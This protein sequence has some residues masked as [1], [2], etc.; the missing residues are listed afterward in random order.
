MSFLLKHGSQN[1]IRYLCISLFLCTAGTTYAAPLSTI[2]NS[3]FGTPTGQVPPGFE[4]ISEEQTSQLDF[5]YGGKFIGSSFAS[6]TTDSITLE[7]PYGVVDLLPKLLDKEA[8]IQA[9]SRSLDTNTE[10]IC[11]EEQEC[12][13][14]EPDIAE[15]ILDQDNFH[16]E[17]LINSNYLETSS[18]DF[19]PFLPASSANEISSSHGINLNFSG[20]DNSSLIYTLDI[21]STI[22]LQEN[23]LRFNWDISDDKL[24]FSEI[25]YEKDT[26]DGHELAVGSF[27][28]KNGN[29]RFINSKN[30]MGIH[31]GSSL[32]TRTDRGTESS[33]PIFIFLQKRGR[34]EV[35]HKNK[36]I[37][38]K[39]FNA[40]NHQLNTRDYPVGAYEITLIIAD[41][42]ETREEKIFFVKNNELPPT[43]QPLFFIE[44]GVQSTDHQNTLPKIED[45]LLFNSGY[46][47]RLFDNIAWRAHYTHTYNTD[48]KTDDLLA[49][50]SLFYINPYF[51][52]SLGLA[53]GKH[54]RH[55]FSSYGNFYL[56]D[57][58]GNFNTMF[59]D[60]DTTSNF[61]INNSPFLLSYASQ[62]NLNLSYPLW[63]SRLNFTARY[64]QI[65][66]NLPSNI[67]Y[68]LH[69]QV[70]LF[71]NR[72]HR[73]NI[74]LDATHEN[75]DSTFLV[76]LQYYFNSDKITSTYTLKQQYKDNPLSEHKQLTAHEAT[77]RWKD[78]NLEN[79]RFEPEVSYAQRSKD[80]SYG[81]KL[82]YEST[83]GQAKLHINRFETENK[84]GTVYTGNSS[85]NIVSIGKDWFFGGAE[86]QSSGILVDLRDAPE[87]SRFQVK[88]DQQ[89][90][91][92]V[93]GG[94]NNFVPLRPYEEYIFSLKPYS[95]ELLQYQQNERHISL[96]PGN[97]VRQ[98]FEVNQIIVLVGRLINEKGEPLA[99]YAIDNAL[100]F[101][102]T[103]AQGWFQIE[104][105]SGTE[106][107][108]IN[109]K[110]KYCRV[111]LAKQY[112]IES[113]LALLDD[114]Q[115]KTL[116]QE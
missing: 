23:R 24:F 3:I 80:K 36:L 101:G 116:N 57:L 7:D 73:F 82:D 62:A 78:T 11:K 76:N 56:G 47:L 61:T 81:L 104:V 74:T 100:G 93:K 59:M 13:Y 79:A 35:F 21:N 87:S 31:Y 69:Y 49:Q 110:G 103:D 107:L 17:I 70:P 51:D 27:T 1:F 84:S 42:G 16:I 5:F 30:I 66:K 115:C 68:G 114:L 29:N 67:S 14:L 6:Y 44:A 71:S 50:T 18:T 72:V 75:D 25:V 19:S 102:S 96:Y 15:V 4:N 32:M 86:N 41:T 37:D 60:S 106:Y 91:T 94:K 109:K 52:I 99:Y 10:Y 89:L 64:N 43:K 9:L 97:I 26:L 54:N 53:A 40:G 48:S 63:R 28:I 98:I 88:I 38:A 45:Q 77:L 12:I 34:V 83:L 20:E 108:T 95:D 55:G 92:I 85:T 111:T 65:E 22:A 105:L 33:T 58:I 46:S 8:I 2:D 90:Q 112:A 39:I 113:G